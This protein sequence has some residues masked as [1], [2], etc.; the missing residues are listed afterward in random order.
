MPDYERLLTANE[1]PVGHQST[2]HEPWRTIIW[3]LVSSWPSSII[4]Y[5]HQPIMVIY[6]SINQSTAMS[7]P[8]AMAKHPSLR[9]VACA[10]HPTPGPASTLLGWPKWLV[11]WMGSLRMVDWVAH[12]SMVDHL[13][14]LD[15]SSW[16]LMIVNDDCEWWMVKWW[17]FMVN[18][19][20]SYT[21]DGNADSWLI[22]DEWWIVMM[23]G[24]SIIC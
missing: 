13:S 19:V 21:Q 5:H 9:Q 12:P 20:S 16:W 23:F 18:D 14:R 22:A 15:G 3:P 2:H 1:P 24:L 11:T 17:L 10:A 7:H 6:G 4:I 8:F